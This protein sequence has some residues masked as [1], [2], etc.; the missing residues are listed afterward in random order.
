MSVF[1]VVATPWAW[2][3]TTGIDVWR[4]PHWGLHL[5]AVTVTYACALWV[6]LTSPRRVTALVLAAGTGGVVVGATV[7]VA[8]G[9]DNAPAMFGDWI[10]MVNPRLGT[11]PLVAALAALTALAAGVLGAGTRTQGRPVRR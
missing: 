6:L 9:Y 3:G 5:T 2:Y 1:S 4:L 7:F 8:L 11:G 10:P